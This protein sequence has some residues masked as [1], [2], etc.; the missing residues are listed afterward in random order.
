MADARGAGG[1]CGA[2]RG[3]L[4]RHRGR[5]GRQ[6]AA[7]TGGSAAGRSPRPSTRRAAT[8]VLVEAGDF[9]IGENKEPDTLPAFYIDKTEV[10]NAAYA[11]FCDGDAS[12][13]CPRASRRTSPIY[14]VVNVL[15]SGCARLRRMGRQAPAQGPRMGEGGA[16]QGRLSLPLGQR[17]G[18]GAGQRRQRQTAAGFRSAQRRQS[19]WSAEHVGQ[20]VGI[21]GS[22]EPARRREPSQSSPRSSRH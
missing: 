3:H 5:D 8:M 20:R 13:P 10:S 4:L 2:W 1:D 7:T 15:I 11:Q 18:H 19:L 22:G 16:R 14:P 12:T 9:L 21:G 17:T 6:D